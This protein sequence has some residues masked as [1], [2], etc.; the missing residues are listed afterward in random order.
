MVWPYYMMVA[1]GGALGASCRYAVSSYFARQVNEL[2]WATLIV[3]VSGSMLA[4]FLLVG[5]LQKLAPTALT[6]LFL[7]TGF[8]GAFTTFSAFSAE[9]LIYFQQQQWFKLFANIALNNIGS[10]L[11]VIIGAYCVTVLIRG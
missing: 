10:F 6:R 2:P 11:G 4:G 9:N 7:F 3:N 1:F 8:L 5:F